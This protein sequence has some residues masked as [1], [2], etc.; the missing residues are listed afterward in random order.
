MKTLRQALVTILIGSI[1][2]FAGA[3]TPTGPDAYVVETAT[4]LSYVGEP[5]AVPDNAPVTLRKG[6]FYPKD[7]PKNVSEVVWRNVQL[8]DV[9]SFS[10]RMRAGGT[11]WVVP[12]VFN[13]KTNTDGSVECQFQRDGTQ[14]YC[15]VMKFQQSGTDVTACILKAKRAY[16][17]ES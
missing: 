6:I 12:E 16:K 10:A 9:T 1:A 15:F 5:F 4:D 14:I 13:V 11:T 8:T 7:G 3:V 17:Q 2:S